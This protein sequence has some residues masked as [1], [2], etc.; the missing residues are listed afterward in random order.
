MATTMA[1]IT[2]ATAELNSIA[3]LTTTLTIIEPPVLPIMPI[4]SQKI[5]CPTAKTI[6]GC[7]LPSGYRQER[8]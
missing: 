7:A 6:F 2:A 5:F 8:A 1:T 4:Y 3:I